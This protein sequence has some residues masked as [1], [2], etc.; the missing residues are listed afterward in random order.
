LKALRWS[1]F[2]NKGWKLIVGLGILISIAVGVK[3]LFF[4]DNSA[5]NFFEQ[6]R[7]SEKVTGFEVSLGGG[8]ITQGYGISRLKNGP[9]EPFSFRGYKP[10]KLYFNKGSLYA[11]LTVYGGIGLPPIKII[12]NELS[13][14]PAD[15]DFNFNNN[16]IEIVNDKGIPVYQ[17]YYRTPSHIVINGIFPI[18]GGLILANESVTTLNPILPT[19]FKLKP[20]FKYPSW[21]YPR[22]LNEN[23]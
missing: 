15:W 13:G 8:G 2:F 12:R 20:I 22:K 16:A 10:I 23:R 14:K 3:A 4:G 7:F 6:P 17:F 1:S 21:K 11:D 19:T 18:P 9:V 5:K